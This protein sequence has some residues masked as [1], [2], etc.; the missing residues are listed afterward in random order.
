MAALKVHVMPRLY[1]QTRTKMP[2]SR[3]ELQIL[4]VAALDELVISLVKASSLELSPTFLDWVA[5]EATPLVE[6]RAGRA[7]DKPRFMSSLTAGDPGLAISLWVRHWICPEIS[8]RFEQMSGHVATFS[9]SGLAPLA[10][11]LP[12]RSVPAWTKYVLPRPGNLQYS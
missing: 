5:D 2:S 8:S 10:E 6:H 12:A 1:L 3:K 11:D 9:E 4:A 7:F